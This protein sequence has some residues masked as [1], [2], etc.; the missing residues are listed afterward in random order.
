MALI[1][2]LDAFFVAP[3]MIKRREQKPQ[4]FFVEKFVLKK[5]Q[6]IT[7]S[8]DPINPSTTIPNATKNA[9]KNLS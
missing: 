2:F 9:V 5:Y 7:S 8:L 3:K 1:F 4:I 6:K